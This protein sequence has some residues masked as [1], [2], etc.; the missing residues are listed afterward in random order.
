MSFN[1][2]ANTYL[3]G[4]PVIPMFLL[5]AN[6]TQSKPMVITVTGQT[7]GKCLYSRTTSS[8][9]RSFQLWHVPGQ[10]INGRNL[11]RQWQP[12]FSKYRL[13]AIRSLRDSRCRIVNTKAGFFVLGRIKKY[14]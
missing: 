3:P 4:S 1:P 13:N 7:P 10:W 11:G 12:I 2:G 6:I 9:D 8:P 14:L 5:I